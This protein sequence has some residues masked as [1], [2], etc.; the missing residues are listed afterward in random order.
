[1]YRLIIIALTLVLLS[2][3]ENPEALQAYY[4][5]LSGSESD[6][7]SSIF[8]R[9]PNFTRGLNRVMRGPVPDHCIDHF[10][11]AYRARGIADTSPYLDELGDLPAQSRS[12]Q[13]LLRSPSS[14][15]EAREWGYYTYGQES[16]RWGTERSVWRL[17]MAGKILSEDDDIIMGVGNLSVRGGGYTSPH[18]SHRRGT[19]VDLRFIGPDGRASAGC[20]Y[21]G[22]DANNC[23]DRAKTFQMIKTL[24]DVDPGNVNLIYINDEEL[25]NQVNQYYQ[26]ITGRSGIARP[27]P[28]HDNHIHLSWN[29]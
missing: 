22:P 18:Q 4:D 14:T 8:G 3:E 20:Y 25:K 13:T 10:I 12:V 21:N 29:N 24:I 23:Y 19:D 28:G 15:E 17:R 9:D 26:S 16:K 7:L 6:Q 1:M 11:Q 5:Q 27:C 2:C